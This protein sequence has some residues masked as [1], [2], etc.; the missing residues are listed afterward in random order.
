MGPILLTRAYPT[1]LPDDPCPILSG[2]NALFENPH[3]FLFYLVVVFEFTFSLPGYEKLFGFLL[4]GEGVV[5]IIVLDLG[6]FVSIQPQ[7]R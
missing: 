5:L 1:D 7:C 6:V 2:L 3:G 4:Y